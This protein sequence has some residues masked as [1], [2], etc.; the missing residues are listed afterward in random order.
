MAKTNEQLE[1]DVWI[2]KCNKSWTYLLI[3]YEMYSVGAELRIIG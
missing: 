3:L 2:L 1:S